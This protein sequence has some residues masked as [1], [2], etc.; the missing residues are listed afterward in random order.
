MIIAPT[1]WYVAVSCSYYPQKPY[2]NYYSGEIRVA[3]DKCRMQNAEC[4]MKLY[5]YDP[6]AIFKLTSWSRP[7]GRF[8]LDVTTEDFSLHTPMVLCSGDNDMAGD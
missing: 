7:Y 3:G 1:A 4:R 6:I 5:G 8:Y 2:V